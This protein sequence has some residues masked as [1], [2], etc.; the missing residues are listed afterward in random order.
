MKENLL[1]L[2]MLENCESVENTIDEIFRKT[3]TWDKLIR[4]NTD[5]HLTEFILHDDCIYE[6]RREESGT[7]YMDIM[8]LINKI[9]VINSALH[10]YAIEYVDKKLFDNEAIEKLEALSTLEFDNLC[11]S[12]IEKN[13]YSHFIS[14]T[15]SKYTPQ[16]YENCT[17]EV[18]YK[19]EIAQLLIEHK[20]NINTIKTKDLINAK[21]DINIIYQNNKE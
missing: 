12:Y 17:I 13:K 15:F 4:V 19:D 16:C 3:F 14:M 18:D 1:G 5:G 21:R 2:K 10:G 7:Y 20:A 6:K 9:Y 8:P 11:N